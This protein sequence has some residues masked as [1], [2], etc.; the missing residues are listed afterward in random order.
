MCLPYTSKIPPTRPPNLP[1]IGK[2]QA[3]ISDGRKPRLPQ[4]NRNHEISKD[5]SITA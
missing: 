1:Y 2:I 3:N 4:H 5:L